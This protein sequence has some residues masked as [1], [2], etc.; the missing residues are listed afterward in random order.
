MKARITMTAV[1]EYEVNP[2]HYP[3]PDPKAMLAV[4]VDQYGRDPF[5]LLLDPRA[6]I[7]VDGEI[8]EPQAKGAE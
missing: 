8:I 4:D 2:D 1:V 3:N 5:M 6:E 7:R